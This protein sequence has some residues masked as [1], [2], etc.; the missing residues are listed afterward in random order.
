MAFLRE[1]LAFAAEDFFDV[2]VGL[3]AELDLVAAFFTDTDALRVD[4][5]FA[6]FLPAGFFVATDF[7]ASALRAGVLRA[8]AF[9]ETVVDFL[10]GVFL[11][12]TFFAVVL[13]AVGDFTTFFTGAVFF[14]AGFLA[15]VLRAV[16]A[17]L[18]V[19]FFVTAFFAGFAF[20]DFAVVDFLLAAFFAAV[21]FFALLVLFLL[22]LVVAMMSPR[23]GYAG[24]PSWSRLVFRTAAEPCTGMRGCQ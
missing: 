12:V 19:D 1:R 21:F 23:K 5:D 2:F 3:P 13:V 6:T 16:V 7:F 8:V 11:L 4:E 10:A 17:L 24:V 9:F 18:T 22:V 15:A 20:A 14:T